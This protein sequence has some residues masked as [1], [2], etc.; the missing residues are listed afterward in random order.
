MQFT[1]ASNWAPRKFFSHIWHTSL[2]SWWCLAYRGSHSFKL[3][4]ILSLL[5]FFIVTKTKWKITL[6]DNTYRIQT[7]ALTHK[8]QIL[9]KIVLSLFLQK[10]QKTRVIGKQGREDG[11]FSALYLT[12]TNKQIHKLFLVY[13]AILVENA[14]KN[15]YI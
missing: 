5:Q 3:C 2:R 9:T 4:G 11:L 7:Y 12:W 8:K 15:I 1:F 13:K 10:S 6:F 14:K